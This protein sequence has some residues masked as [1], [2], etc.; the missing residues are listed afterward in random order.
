MIRRQGRLR[1][2]S[3]IISKMFGSASATV[4]LSPPRITARLVPANG[5]SS[6]LGRQQKW[7]EMLLRHVLWI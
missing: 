4:V 2:D 3:F 7:L 1:R 6:R 5:V